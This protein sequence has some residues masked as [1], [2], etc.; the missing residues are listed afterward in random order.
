MSRK[1][2]TKQKITEGT[3]R[4]DRAVENEVSFTPVDGVPDPPDY[5]GSIAKREWY[6]LIPEIQK[7]NTLEQVDLPQLVLYCWYIQLITEQSKIIK[8]EG[9]TVKITNKGGHS[10]EVQHP[11][12]RTLNEAAEKVIRIA[13]RFG[14]DPASRTKVG[15]PVKQ[16]QDPFKELISEGKVKKLNGTK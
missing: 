5:F 1:K 4:A 14:F 2:P 10:Y 8:K 16:D 7:A 11:A 13:S 12:L 9:T 6:K 15:A 3:F